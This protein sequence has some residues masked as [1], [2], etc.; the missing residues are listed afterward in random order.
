VVSAS[1]NAAET[2]ASNWRSRLGSITLWKRAILSIA[3]ARAHLAGCQQP[4][5]IKSISQ[6]NVMLSSA[7]YKPPILSLNQLLE[8][9]HAMNDALV[10]FAR[11]GDKATYTAVVFK[12]AQQGDLAA[13]M[14]LGEQYIPEQ[15]FQEL[16][17]DVPHCGKSGNEPAHVVFRAG[18]A[19]G[20]HLRREENARVAW[21]ARSG[22]RLS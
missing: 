16:N 8:S 2:G 9:D 3:F 21:E 5:T 15:C 18:I 13:E 7:G 12:A 11:T 19:A 17:Q 20:A 22:P 10:N 4:L 1:R 14:V 6:Q